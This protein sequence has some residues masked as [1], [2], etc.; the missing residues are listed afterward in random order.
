MLQTIRWMDNMRKIPCY[1]QCT[2]LFSIIGLFKLVCCLCHAYIGLQ[3]TG[4]I[5]LSTKKRNIPLNSER[6]KEIL[7]FGMI[8]I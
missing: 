8:V 7:P 2:L 1:T 5:D 4:K 6:R 3:S